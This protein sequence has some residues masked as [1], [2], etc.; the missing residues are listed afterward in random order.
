[1]KGIGYILKMTESKG[2]N[3]LPCGTSESTLIVYLF[4]Y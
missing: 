2:P 4:I 3:T 1:M